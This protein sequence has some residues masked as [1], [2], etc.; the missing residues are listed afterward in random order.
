[1]REIYKLSDALDTCLRTKKFTIAHLHREE[2]PMEM[3]IHDCYE[4]YYVI[5]GGRQ[6]LIQDHLYDIAP[7]DLFCINQFESHYLTYSDTEELE[8]I[9]IFL[10]PDFVKSLRT[11]R[12]NLDAFFSERPEGFSHRMSLTPEQQRIFLFHI[13]QLTSVGGF[14]ADI[15]E[16]A[17]IMELLVFLNQLHS[18]VSPNHVEAVLTHP[19]Y[20]AQIHEAISYINAHIREPISLSALAERLFLS[21]SYLCRIFKASTGTTI[22][23]YIVARRITIAKALLSSGHSVAESQELCG[24]SDYSNFLKAFT[25]TVGIPP[26]KYAQLY[27]NHIVPP[28]SLLEQEM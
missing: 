5:T 12:T 11:S 7:G 23:K 15:Q 2:R 25:R 14:G 3:H 13:S 17:R 18:S 9:M 20:S 28:E 26:K 10:H 21:E 22:S 19:R 8:R 6:F 4:L 16:Y 27:Q 24:F 1:M